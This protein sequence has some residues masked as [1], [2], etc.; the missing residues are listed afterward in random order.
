MKYEQLRRKLLS[1]PKAKELYD[2]YD[3]DFQIVE[4]LTQA[5]Y[6]KHMTQQ[7]LADKSG[8]QRADISKLENADANPTVET[9]YRLAKALDKRLIIKFK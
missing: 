4:A 8:I 6:K 1:N 3:P 5:R 9:L 2:R 7:Q